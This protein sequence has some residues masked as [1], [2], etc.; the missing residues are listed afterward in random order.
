MRSENV[1]NE[2]LIHWSGTYDMLYNKL[3]LEISVL[4]NE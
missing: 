3:F 4:L 2:I 1:F